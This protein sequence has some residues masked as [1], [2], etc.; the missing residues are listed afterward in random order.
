MASTKHAPRRKSAASIIYPVALG[1]ALEWYDIVLFGFLAPMMAPLFFPSHDALISLLLTLGTFGVS[2]FTR[3]LGAVVLGRVADRAGRKQALTLS[4]LLMT[5][6]T[7]T[8]VVLPT[9][10][11]IGIAA[12]ILLILARMIQGFAAGGEYGAATTLLAE[13]DPK[14][15]GFFAA[16]QFGSQGITQVLAAVAALLLVLKLDLAQREVWGWRVAFLF[17]VLA[18]PV[19]VFVRRRLTD[20]EEFIHPSSPP[21]EGTGAQSIGLVAICCGLVVL[22]TATT[23]LTLFMP[24]FAARQLNLPDWI[25]YAGPIVAGSLQTFLAPCAGALSDRTGRILP[26]AIGLLGLLVS[27]VPLFLILTIHPSVVSFISVQVIITIFGSAY[28]G[29]LAAALPELLPVRIRGTGSSVSYSLSVAVFG[30]WAPFIMTALPAITGWS[31]SPSLYLA[32][33]AALSGVALIAAR[34]KGLR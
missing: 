28:L 32:G 27:A 4:M 11:Q 21:A 17:G 13:Q 26:M 6:V 15:R 20:G 34:G 18:G 7:M 1:N 33:C 30:G 2:F 9:F 3:P 16:W 29:P 23:Y 8:I 5:A 31:G 14:R 12:P 19:A 10:K 24:S 25:G 22:A